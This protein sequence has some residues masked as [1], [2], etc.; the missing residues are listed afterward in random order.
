M[1]KS[2]MTFLFLQMLL[3][4]GNFFN[5]NF[6]AVSL[7][8]YSVIKILLIFFV[9][10]YISLFS[11]DSKK[12]RLIEYFSFILLLVLSILE[13]ENINTTIHYLYVLSSFFYLISYY[14]ENM[15]KRY[16]VINVLSLLLIFLDFY[17][18]FTNSGSF[19][20]QLI[21]N[22]LIPISL[23]Y[24]ESRKGLSIFIILLNLLIFLICNMNLIAYNLL[25]LLFIMFLYFL[26]KKDNRLISFL[27]FSIVL[28]IS[29]FDNI[30]SIEVLYDSVYLFDFSF[31]LT[32]CLVIIPFLIYLLFL[33]YKVTHF[34]NY[35]LRLILCSYLAL[36]ITS[37]MI[38]SFENINN[39]FIILTYIYLLVM[40]SSYLKNEREKEDKVSI[41]ALHLGYGGIEKFISSL[42][43]MIDKDIDI[44]SVYMLYDE[45]AFS[46]NA[47]IRYLIPYGPN[48]KKLK[49]AL[50][51]KN[52]FKIIKEMVKAIKI[53]YLKKYEVIESIENINTKYIIT[54]REIHNE[55]VGYYASSNIIKIASEHNY[56]NDDKRYIKRVVKS[57]R[58]VNYFVLV[59]KYLEEYYR[60]I[61][62]CKT[63]YIPNVIDNLPRKTNKVRNHN[64]ISI[65]RLSSLKAQDELILLVNMLKDKYKDITLTIVGDGEEIDNLKYLIKSQKLE[66]NVHLTGFLNRS[67][68]ELKLLESNIFVTTSRS[69]AFGLVVIEAQSYKLPVIAFDSAKG[70]KEI[71][72]DTGILVRNRDLSIMRD[73]VIKLFEDIQYRDEI[74]AASFENSKKY[75]LKNVSKEWNKIIK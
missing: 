43:Q 48:K 54:T 12:I 8:Y 63:L 29:I 75:L 34:K 10:S 20:L 5:F 67:E 51:D 42:T 33:I 6:N 46:Y 40:I 38:L 72:K 30:F 16:R 9:F 28:I 32:S 39:E 7:N 23:I 26:I 58:N 37:F 47:N 61:V 68:I 41:V 74:A 18:L 55:L 15:V 25:G 17:I 64:L 60:P 2:I 21:V 44:I 22:I 69:E 19:T 13:K 56:H 50:S 4:I 73:E 14:R 24:F 52:I 59:A 1:K 49:K 31:N 66:K 57:V 36:L 65:G 11:N 53:L 27:L 71:L 35:Y 45:P 70:I 3:I 62:R